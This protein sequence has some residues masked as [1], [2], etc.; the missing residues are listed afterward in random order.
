MVLFDG[1][2]M[3]INPWLETPGSRLS[4]TSW[5][6][7]RTTA[8]YPFL[9]N[10]LPLSIKVA[11]WLYFVVVS[12]QS[13]DLTFAASYYVFSEFL[14]SVSLLSSLAICD[15]YNAFVLSRLITATCDNK[16]R[17]YCLLSEK[18]CS[19]KWPW[20][21]LSKASWSS[22]RS[23]SPVLAPARA[24]LNSNGD[25]SDNR[26]S[27]YE[28]VDYLFPDLTELLKSLLL[29]FCYSLT[30]AP[31]IESLLLSISMY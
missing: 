21:P 16:I 11:S 23:S 28:C 1:S 19:S 29:N 6:A 31:P 27:T 7:F 30:A 18:M 4:G 3:L 10:S 24:P 2:P 22:S 9:I 15:S 25:C 13:A 5:V 20:P 8:T 12:K 26:D 17:F 14:P